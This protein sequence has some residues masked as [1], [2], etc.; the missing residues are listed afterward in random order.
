ML[1]LERSE[2]RHKIPS[3]L[4]EWTLQ[5]SALTEFLKLGILETCFPRLPEKRIKIVKP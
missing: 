5:A 2:S 1:H 4:Q 3:P